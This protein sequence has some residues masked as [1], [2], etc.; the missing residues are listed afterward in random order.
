MV[1]KLRDE[2]MKGGGA[3]REP[4]TLHGSGK[5]CWMAQRREEERER[6]GE[7]EF[8]VWRDRVLSSPRPSSRPE[9]RIAHPVTLNSRCSRP[10]PRTPHHPGG[11]RRA[12]PLPPFFF[13]LANNLV[14]KY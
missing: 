6:E 3:E 8:K 9:S 1:E 10:P 5:H 12:L 4:K 2:D 13:I 14:M 11:R 7:R